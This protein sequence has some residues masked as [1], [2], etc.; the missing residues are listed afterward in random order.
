MS[1]PSLSLLKKKIRQKK[2]LG[3][4]EMSSAIARG[5][6][7]RKS[8]KFKGKKVKSKKYGGPA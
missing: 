3:S 6:V 4:T 5:L 2:R 1:A 7:A 8:G